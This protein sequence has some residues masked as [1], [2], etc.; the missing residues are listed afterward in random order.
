MIVDPCHKFYTKHQ[1]DFQIVKNIDL[2]N[3]HFNSE[4]YHN[5]QLIDHNKDQGGKKYLIAAN[6]INMSFL[7]MLDSFVI[8]RTLYRLLHNRMFRMDLMRQVILGQFHIYLTTYFVGDK[9]C[10]TLAHFRQCHCEN[11]L[12]NPVRTVDHND[13]IRGF[14]RQL[15]FDYMGVNMDNK[16]TALLYHCDIYQRLTITFQALQTINIVFPD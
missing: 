9:W 11:L 6:Y 10:L 2:Y 12:Q 16:L 14:V 4:N 7:L 3:R 13:R 5:V 1:A 8:M 15:N